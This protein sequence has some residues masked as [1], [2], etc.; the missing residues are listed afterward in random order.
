[1]S[2]ENTSAL[3]AAT[4]LLFALVILAS[5]C[6]GKKVRDGGYAGPYAPSAPSGSMGP[7][8]PV[9]PLPDENYAPPKDAFV[10]VL[11]PGLARTMAYLGVIR[12][13][14][15]KQLTISGIV[16]VE[17]GAVVGAIWASSNGNALD[18]EMHKFKKSTLL[19]FPLLSFKRGTVAE[20]K[21][22]YSFLAE[23]VKV[24]QL[25][26]MRIP[27]FVA[28]SVRN[29]N[30]VLF[31]NSGYA[32]DIL[33]GALSIPGILNSYSFAGKERLSAA[34]ENPFPS[35]R[36]KDLG[37]GKV[38]CVDV[39]GRGDDFS[40]QDNVE[41]HLAALMKS[42]STIGR[43]QLQKCDHVISVPTAGIG[44]LNFGAKAD[45]IYKGR[46]AVK[47]WLGTLK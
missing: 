45:L 46:M 42:A 6:G 32:R 26:K 41:E 17:M 36:A 40:P 13:M 1:M 15:E 33:R 22:I 11:G 24:D 25:E 4:S 2:Y 18:W 3:R 21:A 27:L 29:E 5:G 19:D 23:A 39:L 43:E 34:I 7:E 38:V 8:L 30:G 37:L 12:E 10:L 14:E 35:R 28:S 31:E 44:Y 20:G 9:G 16:G 47:S